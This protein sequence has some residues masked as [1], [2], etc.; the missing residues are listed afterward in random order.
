M[1]ARVTGV[2]YLNDY[3]LVV[4]FADGQQRTVDLGGLVQRRAAYRPIREPEAFRQAFVDAGTHTVSWPAG[5]DVNPEVLLGA[6]SRRGV[7]VHVHDPA[8]ATGGAVALPG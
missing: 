8:T 1:Y 5:V 2:E 4:R 6:K 3:V 7:H